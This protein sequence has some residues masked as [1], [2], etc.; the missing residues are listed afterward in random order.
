MFIE[1]VLLAGVN[2]C[3]EDARRLVGLLEPIECK[4][5]LIVFNPHPG[6]RFRPSEHTRAMAF[7]HASDPA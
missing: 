4:V 3:L 7:R 2:D 5:N 6:T 1:Y